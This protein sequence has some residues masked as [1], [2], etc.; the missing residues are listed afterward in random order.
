[1]FLV[2]FVGGRVFA[3]RSP[4][5]VRNSIF[6]WEWGLVAFPIA[7][8]YWKK[9]ESTTEPITVEFRTVRN[10]LRIFFVLICFI[11]KRMTLVGQRVF[12]LM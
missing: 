4:R 6:R 12:L 9:A 10:E 8:K 7:I 3:D 5:G 2:D 1:L 11:K